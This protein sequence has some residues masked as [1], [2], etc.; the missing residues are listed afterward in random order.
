ME[1]KESWRLL[2]WLAV[3]CIFLL[4]AI[5][6]DILENLSRSEEMALG[7]VM[8]VIGSIC[9]VRFM[10]HVWLKV[11]KKWNADRNSVIKRLFSIVI[12]AIIIFVYSET[13]IWLVDN[14][15]TPKKCLNYIV[16]GAVIA[17]FIS[18]GILRIIYRH[19]IRSNNES[20]IIAEEK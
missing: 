7:F 14:V 1:E 13:S 20:N 8:C 11:D 18:L 15:S 17:F 19:E 3:G 12:T 6:F 9:V 16:V 4:M 5:K 2:R 10:L